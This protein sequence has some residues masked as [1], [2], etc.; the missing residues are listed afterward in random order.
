M[1]MQRVV[2]AV[3]GAALWAAAV[4]APAGQGWDGVSGRITA[5]T[6]YVTGADVT[7]EVRVPADGPPETTVRIGPLPSSVDAGT[8]QVWTDVPGAA[9][10][11]AE[12]RPVPEEWLETLPDRVA[13]LKEREALE[14]ELA[15]R[16][17]AP[18]EAAELR[19]ELAKALIE[20]V[21]TG[22][23]P[24]APGE[25]ASAS[26]FVEDEV[27]R[28]HDAVRRAEEAG[29][30]IEARI[31]AVERRLAE[32]EARWRGARYARVRLRTAGGTGAVTLGVRYRVRNASWTPVVVADLAPDAARVV[33]DLA[34]RV[35][36][37]T[38]EDWSEVRMTVSSAQP[39]RPVE[40]P[41]PAPWFVDVYEPAR[42]K[43]AD[44][45]AAESPL[46]A[47]RTTVRAPARPGAAPARR[48]R[49]EAGV[50]SYAVPGRV[51]VRSGSD[52]V[53][54][55]GRFE[56]PARV[57]VRAVPQRSLRGFLVARFRYPGEG[58]VPPGERVLR[59]AGRLVG[60]VRGGPLRPGEEV[61]WGFGPDDRVRVRMLLDT[62][63]RGSS[64]IFGSKRRVER[65]YRI[66][67]ENLGRE[68]LPAELVVSTPVSRDERLKVSLEGTTPGHG[69]DARGTPGVLVWR[70]DLEPG[71]K[72]VYRLQMALEFPKDL[73]V[74]GF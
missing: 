33:L 51:S 44:L 54:P 30:E 60:T 24:L 57:V 5:V 43:A 10:L 71:E 20:G 39:A 68:K 48:V 16:V 19:L 70:T 53:L 56:A 45:A 61:S 8:L 38:G 62:D 67:L 15:E 17:T 27:R 22:R 7:R 46:G 37:D 49:T 14:A 29:R 31:R 13:L 25:W 2:G 55:L 18:R 59:R 12:V 6:V 65:R 3:V 41:R 69:P 11:W 9:V 36:Q 64:G 4:S 32:L 52:A 66:E 73:R 23:A 63:F 34:A 47:E 72:A 50:S 40:P 58:M 26:G 1:R 21:R 42:R 35:R 28:H 74:E